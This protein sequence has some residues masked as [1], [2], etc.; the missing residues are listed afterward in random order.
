MT[1]GGSNRVR[2]LV[3]PDFIMDIGV[4]IAFNRTDTTVERNPQCGDLRWHP[5]ASTFA[6][7]DNAGQLRAGMP[8][9][10]WR[11][12]AKSS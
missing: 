11:M 1:F 7:R 2:V 12:P 4:S 5:L 10:S 8:S 9:Y 3:L 6:M